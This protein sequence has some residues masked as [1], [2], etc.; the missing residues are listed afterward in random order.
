MRSNI[1]FNYGALPYPKHQ[2]MYMDGYVNKF[3]QA[4]GTIPATDFDFA[5]RNTI[6]SITDEYKKK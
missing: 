1:Q 3:E 5:L 2:V 6:E 4:F